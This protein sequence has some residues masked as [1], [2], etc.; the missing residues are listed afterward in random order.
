MKQVFVEMNFLIGAARPCPDETA[1]QLLERSGRDV[2]LW[3]PWCAVTE[4]RRTLQRGILDDDLGFEKAM[5]KFAVRAGLPRQDRETHQTLQRFAKQVRDAR[6]VAKGSTDA[7]LDEAVARMEVIP[8]SPGAVNETLRI[9]QTKLLPPFDEMIL[10]SVLAKAAELHSADATRDLYFCNL[11]KSDFSPL[12][13]GGAGVTR[14]SLEAAY[15][16]C[17]LRYLDSF[18][19]PA[20]PRHAAPQ[21]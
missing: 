14:P 1:E 10:G 7:R 16:R 3:V 2:V 4:A 20:S 13:R 8:P 21:P 9:W 15:A 12:D 18:E 11:N 19:V 6:R 5:L 17:G